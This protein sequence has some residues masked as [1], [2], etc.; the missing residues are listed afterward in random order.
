MNKK[1]GVTALVSAVVV[2]SLALDV[3]AAA[4]G[5]M[6]N[7]TNGHPGLSDGVNY[8]NVVIDDNT[9]NTLTFTVTLLPPLTSIA[10]SNFGLQEF[11]FNVVGTHLLVDAAATNSQWT[12]PASWQANVA[13][14][15]NQMDGFGRF[16]VSVGSSGS[17]RLSPLV[18]SL[19]NTS[20]SLASFA[21][22]SSNTAAQGNVFF[23]A[24]IAG[25][26]APGA[27][28]S[29]YFGGSLGFDPASAIV[30]LPAAVWMLGM[31][32]TALAG[33][34]RHRRDAGRP[35]PVVIGRVQA[36]RPDSCS[37]SVAGST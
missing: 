21:E 15:P 37:S 5:Y 18:F 1:F 24:H 30:P 8:A 23:A 9:A 29:A 19:K 4:V 13:P 28:T 16:E 35:V 17:A 36:T 22:L 11:G 26:T 33:V 10:G 20:L 31:G 2:A 14:P 27:L 7:Q 6:L 32:L 12:L 25:F 3:R 34:A